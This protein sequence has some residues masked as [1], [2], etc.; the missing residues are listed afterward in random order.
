MMD[1]STTVER[2]V[3]QKHRPSVGI[4]VGSMFGAGRRARSVRL[5]MV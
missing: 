5:K 4:L 3:Y 1:T 2:E